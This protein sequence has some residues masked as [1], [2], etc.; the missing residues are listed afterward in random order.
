MST[1]LNYQS[2]LMSTGKTNV[3]VRNLVYWLYCI[4]GYFHP[5][6]FLPSYT[7]KRFPVFSIC[8]TYIYDHNLFF[9]STRGGE[10]ATKFV[11]GGSTYR[12]NSSHKDKGRCL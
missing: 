7:C 1:S 6:L 8:L 5:M 12:G 11:S 4:L 9:H 2:I 10:E 3:S